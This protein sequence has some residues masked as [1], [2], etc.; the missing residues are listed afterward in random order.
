MT[1]AQSNSGS[2]DHGRV[3]L[4]GAS[5]FIGRHFCSAYGGVPLVDGNGVVDL[6]QADRV[7]AAIAAI[8]PTAVIHLAAQSSVASSFAKPEET[9]AVNF[10]GTLNLLTALQSIQFRGV[11]VFVSSAD[12]YGSVADSELP[13]REDQPAR[14]RNPYAV[15][16]IAAESLC[17]QWSQT[18]KFRVIVVRLFNQ[19]GPGHDRRFAIADFAH[20]IVEIKRGL[21]PAKL[22][23]G[24]LDVTRDFTD[25]RDTVRA[26]HLL[27]TLGR[28]G[29]VYNIC[30][31]KERTLRSIVEELLKLEGVEA[32]VSTDTSRM[33][34]VE[35]RRMVGD[36]SKISQHV[37]WKPEIS[38]ETTVLDIL[39]DAEDNL[40]G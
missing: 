33:R 32:E 30:S 13:T 37:G 31:G 25:V 17:Y 36:F 26:L 6:Q 39:K 1:D 19:Y 15:S 18:D 16:K 2:I 11:F 8:Q 22:T 3:L 20:Q 35:Q 38:T 5:G 23:T 24:D 21:R 34:P 9:Y 29:E 7:K 14:P 12:I 27:L 28:T 4:T 40:N 10:M